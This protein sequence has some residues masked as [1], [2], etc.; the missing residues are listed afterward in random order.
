MLE[1]IM[2]EIKVNN[3]NDNIH[4]STLKYSSIALFIV[5]ASLY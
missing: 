4:N 1:T 5:F 3:A 2:R